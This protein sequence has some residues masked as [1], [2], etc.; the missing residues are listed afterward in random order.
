MFGVIPCDLPDILLAGRFSR[1]DKMSYQ[2]NKKRCKKP[3]F[4]GFFLDSNIALVVLG[5]VMAQWHFALVMLG[6][7]FIAAGLAIDKKLWN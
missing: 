5:A 4:V 1:E 7:S 3:T 2:K 6:I